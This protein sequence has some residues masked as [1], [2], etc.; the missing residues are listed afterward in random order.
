MAGADQAAQVNGRAWL[1]A[2]II[3]IAATTTVSRPKHQF[4]HECFEIVNESAISSGSKAAE[5]GVINMLP[6]KCRKHLCQHPG[7]FQVVKLVEDEDNGIP[8]LLRFLR[9]I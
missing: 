9:V 8:E 1:L 7:F 6:H 3:V 2:G 5:V 4:C